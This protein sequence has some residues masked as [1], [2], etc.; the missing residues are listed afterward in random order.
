MSFI[1]AVTKKAS[2]QGEKPTILVVE[3]R[4]QTYKNLFDGDVIVSQGTEIVKEIKVSK[5]GLKQLEA[6]RAAI[7][8]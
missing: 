2:E 3:S 1:C 7:N 6:I 4:S 5:E 8:G